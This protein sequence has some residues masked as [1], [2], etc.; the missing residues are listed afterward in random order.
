MAE[1]AARIVAEALDDSL[2]ML[3]VDTAETFEIDHYTETTGE[4]LAR[5][6]VAAL[7][8]AGL[9]AEGERTTRVEYGI[10]PGS[11]I[12]VFD[13]LQEARREAGDSEAPWQRTVT[14]IRGPW[15]PVSEEAQT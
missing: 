5:I 6:T 15:V 8:E 2:T 13:T 4:T 12:D 11:S 9:L 14:E 3:G 1:N 10:W 7:R